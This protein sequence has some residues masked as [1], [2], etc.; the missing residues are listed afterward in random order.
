[1]KKFS[2]GY[3]TLI[4]VLVAGVVGIGIQYALFQMSTS[5]GQ[6]QLTQT[7]EN[8]LYTQAFACREV[9]MYEISQNSAIT[10]SFTNANCAYTILNTG[11]T[12]REIRITIQENGYTVRFRVLAINVSTTPTV[13]SWRRVITF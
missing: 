13:S 4:S 8:Q 10:G 12:N 9:A 11:G 3:V 6:T 5:L 7:R 1:M 2:R